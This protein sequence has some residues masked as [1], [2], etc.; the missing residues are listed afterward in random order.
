MPPD[1]RSATVPV[2]STASSTETAPS[3]IVPSAVVPGMIA[4]RGAA[5]HNLRGI[6]LDL[7]RNR[8][9][10]V[11]GVSGSGKSSLAFDTLFAEGRRRYLD[12]LSPQARL[13]SEQLPRAEV[14]SITGLPPTLAIRQSGTPPRARTLLATLTEI[15]DH[16]RVLFARAGTPRC[17]TCTEPVSQQSTEAIVRQILALEPGLKAMI[18]APLVRGKKG[19]HVDLFARIARQG[20]VRARV[21]GELVDISQ[22]PAL[23]K[24][25][26]HS[27]EAVVD[28]I[29]VKPGI[30]SRLTESVEAAVKLSGGTCLITSQAGEG[31]QDRLY[32]TTLVCPTCEVS[33]PPVEPRTF[34]FNSPYGACPECGGL[35]Q[36]SA[37][38][39]P[40]KSQ[41][42][43]QAPCPACLGERLAPVGR[44][45]LYRET[46]LPTF[47]QKTVSQ[48]ADIVRDWINDDQSA[49]D[50]VR[51][52]IEARILPEIATRLR[53]LDEVGLGYIELDRP[54]T[55]LSGGEL[56]RARLAQALGA[57]LVG[58]CYILDEPTCGL[59]P[60]DTARLL[61]ALLDLRDRR[62]S[63][64]VVEHDLDVITAAD[65]VVDLGPGAGAEGGQV[66]GT[67]SPRELQ[68][69]PSS[70]TGLALAAMRQ[71]SSS[72]PTTTSAPPTDS[73]RIVSASQRNLRDL[74]VE[75]PL[76]R[77]VAITGVSGSGKSTLIMETLVPLLKSE[78]ARREQERLAALHSASRKG[79]ARRQTR[80]T[81]EP[82]QLPPSD[83]SPGNPLASMGQL[84]G[85]ESLRRC[86]VADQGSL[87][88]TARSNPATAT[89]LWNDLRRF[90][91]RTSAARLRGFTASRFSL[92]TAGGRCEHCRGHGVTRVKLEFLPDLFVTCTACRGRRFN[93]A[94]LEARF[95]GLSIADVLDLRIDAAL[96]LFSAF[97][98][99]RSG[100]HLLCDVGLGYL[101]LGQPADTLSGG[102][103]Q[104]LKLARELLA[105]PPGS[106]TE[107]DGKTLFILDEPTS[108]LH[109]A[110]IHR[111]LA[112]LRRL[113]AAGH[114]VVV[115][116]H[117]LE[118][119]A[120]ADW[121]IDLG[122]EGGLGGGQI[123]ATGTVTD[124]VHSGPGHTA[125]ALRSRLGDPR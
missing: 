120:A 1:N 90:F 110:D 49:A 78:L 51:R 112:L 101:T 98:R 45:V 43:T 84:T 71:A 73:I 72:V 15:H 22:P 37:E 77:L 81:A 62:T 38:D 9:V 28:R 85:G 31:W 67:G 92:T 124:L 29:I 116:E 6:D 88:R 61:S 42:H 70:L 46:T 86:V 23:K 83:S 13:F 48:A 41:E 10:V 66:V 87:G 113:I 94:T 2:S 95:K 25:Q 20:L 109:V 3:A 44:G 47:L 103:A 17:P 19:A 50:P 56:Q 14:A 8:L 91:A 11:T 125:S 54:A 34:S 21:N 80:S 35:G 57:G 16:L 64:V 104:R 36:L 119:V 52:E 123:V 59:H 96:P 68:D 97:E 82:Q 100:L 40:N 53:F 26:S 115:I 111:L 74:T 4:I 69:Q 114:S 117:S 102:E 106:R 76:G 33:L 79:A 7:P 65:H 5:T 99:L 12:T 58:V 24:T 27:I 18:L 108:G 89:G 122:P 93:P 32:S 55:T 30:D 105:A 121:V 75:I 60:R 107:G 118:V 63:L 39:A